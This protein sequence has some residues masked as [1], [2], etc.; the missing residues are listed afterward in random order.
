MAT[1]R[2]VWR[3]FWP[4]V[5]EY[6]FRLFANEARRCIR[7]AGARIARLLRIGAS[8]TLHD[9]GLRRVVAL[10]FGGDQ[11][12]WRGSGL[13]PLGERRED[14]MLRVDHRRRQPL[15]AADRIRSFAAANAAMLDARQKE[16][17]RGALQLV[18]STLSLGERL[19]EGDRA[20]A[21]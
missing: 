3:S 6:E 4:H 15:S 2:G 1:A 21:D 13:D 10:V 17:P 12:L 20:Q 9:D 19:V 5:L 16:E 8:R 18:R 7:I 11:L 14:V